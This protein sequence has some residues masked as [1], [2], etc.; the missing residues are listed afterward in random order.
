[1]VH[2][3]CSDFWS[4]TLGSGGGRSPGHTHRVKE[5][6]PGFPGPVRQ[7]GADE[8]GRGTEEGFRGVVSSVGPQ[9]SS[10]VTG[11]GRVEVV[12][13]VG[14]VSEGYRGVPGRSAREETDVGTA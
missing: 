6:V 12:V 5:G 2:R 4:S 3:H 9:T 1:M 10:T 13:M 11:A 8:S 7:E 14:S